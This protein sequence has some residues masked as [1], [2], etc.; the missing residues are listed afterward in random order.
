MLKKLLVLGVVSGILAAVAAFI[1]QKVYITAEGEGFTGIVTPVKI[2]LSCL[3]SCVVASIG[4]FLMS[5]VLKGNTQIVFNLLFAI[6]TFASILLPIGFRLPL[7]LEAPELFPGLTVP[8]HFF[9]VLAWFTLK[10]LF[11]KS[12]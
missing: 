6:I 8:M 5:K 10:P 2:I 11:A 4:Y 1:Y 12:A 7:D 9:P 3:I